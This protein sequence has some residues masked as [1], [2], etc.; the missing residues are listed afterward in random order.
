MVQDR[1]I[2]IGISACLAGEPVRYDGGDSY[3]ADLCDY[4]SGLFT[5]VPIC[6]ELAIGMGVPRAP[7]QLV[8]ESNTIRALGVNDRSVDVTDRLTAYAMQSVQSQPA[9]DG[10]VVKARS[11]S[12]GLESTPLYDIN[13]QQTGTTSGI[14]TSTLRA[15][16]QAIPLIDESC[17]GNKVKLDQFALQICVYAAF[18]VQVQE[19][20]DKQLAL[21]VFRENLAALAG[22]KVTHHIAMPGQLPA[23]MIPEIFLEQYI[24]LIREQPPEK[25]NAT[26]R[27]TSASSLAAHLNTECV[28]ILLKKLNYG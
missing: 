4:L 8:G 3:L 15:T 19:T 12:C 28:A 21:E 7:I 17:A 24:T 18:R 2:N 9:V 1:P 11:P 20:E 13:G 27:L 10:F 26:Q 14:F 23:S 25:V 5:L 16:N 22:M 6:P